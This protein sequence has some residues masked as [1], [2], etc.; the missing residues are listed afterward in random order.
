[1]RSVI[2]IFLGALCT[3]L[4]ITSLSMD[5]LF[6]HKD[7]RMNVFK[8]ST[9]YRINRTD[10]NQ[11]N[12]TVDVYTLVTCKEM[13]CHWDSEEYK[14]C[15]WNHTDGVAEVDIPSKETE[16]GGW[17]SCGIL[18]VIVGVSGTICSTFQFIHGLEEPRKGEFILYAF[19]LQNT[20]A[21]F[22]LIAVALANTSDCRY[23]AHSSLQW[24]P[25]VILMVIPGFLYFLS[26]ALVISDRAFTGE[27]FCGNYGS[28]ENDDDANTEEQDTQDVAAKSMSVVGLETSDSVV[29]VYM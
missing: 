27:R 7:F 17:L 14:D 24:G 28:Y 29:T 12:H 1:M 25:S 10:G 8:L 22:A 18:A 16:D 9:I 20:A 3:A 4:V 19:V 23:H 2:G 13:T 5:N 11:S 26:G 6:V 15:H 21:M